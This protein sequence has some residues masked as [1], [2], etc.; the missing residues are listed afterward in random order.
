M[1]ILRR[2]PKQSSN[3]YTRQ[4]VVH[5]LPVIDKTMFSESKPSPVNGTDL[6]GYCLHIP[7]GSLH[8]LGALAMTM[9]MAGAS[10][11]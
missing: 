3:V 1:I 8:P 6:T 10:R 4:G 9:A 11:R 5:N 2:N 7:K